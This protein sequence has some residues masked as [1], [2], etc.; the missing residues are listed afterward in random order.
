MAESWNF[1]VLVPG[2]PGEIWSDAKR[3]SGGI[4]ETLNCYSNP[5]RGKQ[6]VHS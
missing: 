6:M 5:F 1:V 2:F 4:L 3:A